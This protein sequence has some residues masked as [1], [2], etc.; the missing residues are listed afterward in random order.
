M[1]A[2]V[3]AQEETEPTEGENES[4]D[5]PLLSVYRE[6]IGEPESQRDVYVG[7]GLFFAGI[8][9]GVVGLGAFAYSGTQ[10]TG[11]T[12]F[13]QLRE[14]ALV[15]TMLALPAISISVAVLL[16]VGQRTNIASLA[17]SGVCV[18]A[19]VWL[20]QVY[21][22][23]WTGTGNDL[24]VIGLYSLGL[25]VL[26]ASTGSALVAQYVDRVTPQE[27]RDVTVESGV[28]ESTE[29]E[30]VSDEQVAADIE[31]AM[32]E[33][34]INWG[35]VE[36]R[37]T[38]KRLKLDMPELDH[39]TESNTETLSAAETRSAGDSVDDAVSGLRQL[40]GDDRT[41]GRAESPDAQV[42]ALT[43][44]HQQREAELE[45]GVDDEGPLQRLRDRL[46]R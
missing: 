46:F 26:A 39:D 40:Q 32:D 18:V 27:Q 4:P 16:P 45:T 23:E 2:E 8:A 20:I 35:G 43:Q 34:S 17:G 6:Y 7:F 37:P 19:I 5:S 24:R 36:H 15:V 38:T 33:A 28:E 11:S 21:P 1:S 30:D 31:A 41:T 12:L 25:V 10:E 14:F 22:F 44:L 3:A 13:W 9:L 29:G 42:D